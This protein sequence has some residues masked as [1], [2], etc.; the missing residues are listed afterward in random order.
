MKLPALL[1]CLLLL[2]SSKAQTTDQP[3]SI[4][5][6]YL[7]VAVASYRETVTVKL[8]C[9]TARQGET[10]V[11]YYLCKATDRDT[12]CHYVATRRLRSTQ[13]SIE[14]NITP[15]RLGSGKY[16]GAFYFYKDDGDQHVRRTDTYPNKYVAVDF[17]P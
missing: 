13:E 8:T 9:T 5:G 11:K 1:F 16:Y 14:Y 15:G 17:K 2:N 12:V 4:K 7:N 6:S 3:I 10:R